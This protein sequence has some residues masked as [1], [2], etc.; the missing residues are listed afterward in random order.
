MNPYLSRTHNP[1]SKIDSY[2]KRIL[3]VIGCVRLKEYGIRTQTLEHGLDARLSSI[4][5]KRIPKTTKSKIGRTILHNH[6]KLNTL[7]AVSKKKEDCSLILTD[8]VDW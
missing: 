2:P 8:M 1:S 4:A 6:E 5:G 3:S 7:E